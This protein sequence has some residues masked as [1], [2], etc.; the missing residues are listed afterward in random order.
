MTTGPKK[1]KSQM[2]TMGLSAPEEDNGYL[3]Y[4]DSEPEYYEPTPE[5][6]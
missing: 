3:E 4:P 6:R 5:Y 1:I 2:P